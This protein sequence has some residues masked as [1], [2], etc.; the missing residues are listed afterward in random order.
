MRPYRAPRQT[1]REG[2]GLGRGAAR[3]AHRRAAGAENGARLLCPERSEWTELPVPV[4]PRG[5]HQP[6]QRPGT[7]ADGRAA[8]PQAALKGGFGLV[9]LAPGRTSTGQATD[10]SR[11]YA[12]MGSFCKFAFCG[13]A[14]GGRGAGRRAFGGVRAAASRLYS[15]TARADSRAPGRGSASATGA[16][17]S[18]NVVTGRGARSKRDGRAGDFTGVSG[19][20]SASEEAG[21]FVG[22]CRIRAV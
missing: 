1:A 4:F 2:S 15:S 12:E 7:A 9:R 6:S 17:R 19:I 5:Q 21:A 22:I 20:R 10:C 18:G 14:G 8:E 11:G 13:R 3:P 16:N